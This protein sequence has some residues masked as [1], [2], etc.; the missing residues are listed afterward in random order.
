MRRYR[1]IR[2]EF[3]DLQGRRHGLDQPLRPHP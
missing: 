2:V 3:P 1:S